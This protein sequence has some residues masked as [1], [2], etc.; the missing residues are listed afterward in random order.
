MG[1]EGKKTVRWVEE[2]SYTGGRGRE[3]SWSRVAG[4]R[5]SGTGL[6]SVWFCGRALVLSRG[7][8]LNME[9]VARAGDWLE[10]N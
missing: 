3:T 5:F 8:G 1:E 2:L 6:V 7:V 4:H 10:E 9:V